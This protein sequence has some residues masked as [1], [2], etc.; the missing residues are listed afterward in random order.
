LKVKYRVPTPNDWYGA[1]QLSDSKRVYTAVATVFPN[2]V[3]GH[4][5]TSYIEYGYHMKIGFYEAKETVVL[6][7]NH[8]S[9]SLICPVMIWSSTMVMTAHTIATT[10]RDEKLSRFLISWRKQRY[11]S[12]DIWS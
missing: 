9:F 11:R 8:H 4:L 6:D 5:T 1:C 12:L 7:S 3:Y 10:C 2:H